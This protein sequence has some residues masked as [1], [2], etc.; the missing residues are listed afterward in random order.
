MTRSLADLVF[1]YA[2]L[3]ATT[4]L[5]DHSDSQNDE[6]FIKICRKLT[7]FVKFLSVLL[8]LYHFFDRKYMR[9]A[10]NRR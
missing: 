8:K 3:H 7:D 1:S 9:D 6:F 10:K 5:N 2:N 4:E